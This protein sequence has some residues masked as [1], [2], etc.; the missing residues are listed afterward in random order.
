VNRD[1]LSQRELQVFCGAGVPPAI[2]L[3][4]AFDQ[5]AGGTPAPQRTA[6]Q[7]G[8]IRRQ[9]N[10]KYFCAKFQLEEYFSK[11]KRAEEALQPFSHFSTHLVL[12]VPL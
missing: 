5:N 11:R 10:S 12:A 6:C 7:R 8:C 1:P 2:F 9:V 3:S 4:S